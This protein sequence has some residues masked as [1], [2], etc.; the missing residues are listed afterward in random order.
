MIRIVYIVVA[1]LLS[2]SC[3]RAD[4]LSYV[5]YQGSRAQ[6]SRTEWAT[7]QSSTTK[8]ADVNRRRCT[9]AASALRAALTERDGEFWCE[10]A[11]SH[12]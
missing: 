3:N 11:A 6:N 9:E 8:I 10:A 5:L 2:A 1:A 4:P 12:R 7:F